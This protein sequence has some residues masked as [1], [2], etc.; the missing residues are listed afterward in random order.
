MQGLGMALAGACAST[1]LVQAAVGTHPGLYTLLG[2]AAGGFLHVPISGWIK[3]RNSTATAA[4]AKQE[5]S[6][7][8]SA[9]TSPM[10]KDMATGPAKLT[11]Y[12]HL[13]ISRSAC[14]LVA[15]LISVGVLAGLTLQP[16]TAASTAMDAVFVDPIVGGLLVAAAQVVALLTRGSPLGVSNVFDEIGNIVWASVDAVTTLGSSDDKKAQQKKT[17]LSVTGLAFAGGMMLAAS[18][19][20]RFVLLPMAGGNLQQTL[21]PARAAVGGLLIG[22]G[23]RVSGGCTSGHGISGLGLLSTSSL[24]TT[25]CMFGGGILFGH[26]L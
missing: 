12:E 25:V 20:V 26:I 16:K 6:E 5:S 13:E 11:I 1:V 15:D 24:I 14:V 10:S 21:S 3:K 22:L 23:S 2:A 4:L 17:K 8:Y 9:A 18:A 7:G 19:T